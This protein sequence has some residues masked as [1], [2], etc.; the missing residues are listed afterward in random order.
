MSI[1]INGHSTLRSINTN[2][3]KQSVRG[4]TTGGPGAVTP[5]HGQDQD[6]VILT[7]TASLLQRLSERI[8]ETPIVDQERVSEIRAAIAEGRYE[9]DSMKVAEKMTAFESTLARA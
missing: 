9:I 2:D 6:K 3:S 7:D 5:R 1:E 8:D 4:S